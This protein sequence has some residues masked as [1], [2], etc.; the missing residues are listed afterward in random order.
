[1]TAVG[2]LCA[3]AASLPLGNASVDLIVTSPPYWRLRSY[4]VEGEIGAEPTPADYI[5]SLVRC[6]REWARV[7]KPSGSIFVNLGD[8]YTGQSAA[9]DVDFSGQGARG[10]KRRSR[11]ARVP[12]FP[13]KS[14]LLLP[15]RYR[16]ACLDE[17]ALTVRAVLVW[18]KTNG[19]PESATDRAHRSHEDWV[20]LTLGHRYYSDI[21]QIR[22]P[23]LGPREGGKPDDGRGKVPG[24]VWAVSTQPLK[25][26]AHLGVKHFAAFPMEWPRRLISGWCPPGGVVLD[27]LGGSGTTAAVARALG[28]IGITVDIST[29]YCALAQWRINDPTQLMRAARGLVER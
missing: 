17:L 5:G 20:H 9:G 14:L 28:R 12:G 1:M 26:P 10:G 11:P 21:D 23:R 15:E 13:V 6:T 4:G 18:S 25:P 19:I 27:P 3:D 7:L 2:V 24:S 8:R 16:I 22:T 29:E